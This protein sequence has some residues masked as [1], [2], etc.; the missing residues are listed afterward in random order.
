VRELADLVAGCLDVMAVSSSAALA[1]GRA[2]GAQRDGPRGRRG[3]SARDR[4]VRLR[5]FGRHYDAACVALEVA[6]ALEAVG[7]EAGAAE[8]SE[9]AAAVLGP[10][11]CVNPW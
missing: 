11:G 8:A 5:A 10:L 3:E 6:T 2:L 7:D 1:I 9:R 4:R